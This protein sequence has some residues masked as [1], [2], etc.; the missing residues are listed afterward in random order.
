[1]KLRTQEELIKWLEKQKSDAYW[2]AKVKSAGGD[3]SAAQWWRGNG[4]M[5][6]HV[7]AWVFR[8]IDG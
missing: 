5:C 1:M 8:Q 4:A 2:R 7:V 3:E 6:G